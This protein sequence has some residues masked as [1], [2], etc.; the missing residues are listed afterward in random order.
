MLSVRINVRLT[1][2]QSLSYMRW[3]V[4]SNVNLFLCFYLALN[5]LSV[6]ITVWLT[7][8]LTPPNASTCIYVNYGVESKDNSAS[9]LWYLACCLVNMKCSLFWLT[10]LSCT[11]VSVLPWCV[12]TNCFGSLE[13]LLDSTKESFT[14]RHPHQ[15]LQEGVSISVA[16]DYVWGLMACML[17]WQ[18]AALFGKKRSNYY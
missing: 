17:I 12:Q 11:Y 2:N 5:A 9:W 13:M 4:M 8:T 3:S 7:A 16:N 6:R 15:I 18:C 1:I 14:N 10:Q